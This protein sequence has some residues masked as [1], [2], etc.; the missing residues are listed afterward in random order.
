MLGAIAQTEWVDFRANKP[1]IFQFSE[2]SAEKWLLEE[3]PEMD[4]A[5]WEITFTDWTSV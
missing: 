2:P 3:A 5:G 1:V 4:I